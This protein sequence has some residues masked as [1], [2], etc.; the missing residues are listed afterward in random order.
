MSSPAPLNQSAAS[1]SAE[2]GPILAHRGRRADYVALGCGLTLASVAALC[3]FHSRNEILLSGD[4]VAHINIA[5]HVFDSRTPGLL[6]LGSVWLPLPHLLTIPFVVDNSMWQSGIGGSIISMLSYVCTGLGIFRLLSI[7]SRT[8]AWLGTAVCAANPNLL[9]VQTTALNEPL[10]LAAFLWATVCFTE[11]FRRFGRDDAGAARWLQYG[12]VAL[13]AGVFTRYDGWFLACVS[14]IVIAPRL[15]A[16]LRKAAAPE[17]RRGVVKALLLTALG[18]T[19]WLA[20]N[21]GVYGNPLEF[22]NGPYSAKAIAQRTTQPG[23]PP[24]PG[25]DHVLTAG[26][27]FIKAA[28]L[29]IGD[30]RLARIIVLLAVCGSAA[31][32]VRGLGPIV[33]LLWSPVAFYALSIA[34]GSVPIFLPVWWPFSYYNAR[35]G[36]ELLPA[37]AAGIALLI[38]TAQGVASRQRLRWLAVLLLGVGVVT[39]WQ[40]WR[41]VPLCLRETRANG[42]ARMEIDAKLSEALKA[43]PPKSTVLAYTGAHSG[44]FELAAF[45][46][47]QTIN[48]GNLYIWDASLT[49]PAMSADYIVACAG[50]PVA[51]A[52]ARH[53]GYLRLVAKFDVHGEQPIALYR[54]DLRPPRAKTSYRLSV[55]SYP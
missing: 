16:S 8:A 4:A 39:Y 23:A 38:H 55:L 22:A 24:Y 40:C 5:R 13:T 6:Q 20:Y 50:D 35:Y 10:Y 43:L 37:I 52:V 26:T 18:P 15:L 51:E 45:P 47:R 11:A 12:A 54:S 25:K 41:Q 42:A 9:Y 29:N 7:W 14:W 21:F 19:L 33:V 1:H 2:T 27:Y 36:L 46:L 30:S 53:P 32:L 48:E 44:A 3:F 17:F 49:L 28:Q 34:Y 31:G